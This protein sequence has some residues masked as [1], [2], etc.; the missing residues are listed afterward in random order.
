MGDKS[1][2]VADTLLPAKKIYKKKMFTN[3]G[4][5]AELIV[6]DWGVKSTPA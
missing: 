5:V 4:S 2:G 6:P 3:S 1:E